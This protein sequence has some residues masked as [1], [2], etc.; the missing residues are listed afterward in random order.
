[1]F[2]IGIVGAGRLSR[3][4]LRH[5]SRIPDTSFVYFDQESQY[6]EALATEY[7]GKVVKKFSD[8]LDCV[9][10]ID[11]ITPNSI[12][13]E[14]AVAS[15]NAGKHTFIEKPLDV[16]CEAAKPVVEAANNSNVTVQVGHVLRYF[17]MYNKAHN[18][19]N[20]G[21]VGVPAAIRMTRGGGMPGGEAGWFADHKL[22]GGIFVDLAIHD[23][24][25]LL[26]SV[27]P[28]KE[29]YAKSVGAKT[30][31]GPD[32]GLA[33]L[34]F[35]NGCIAHVESTW[36]DPQESRTAFEICGPD[37]LLDYDSR[38]SATLRSGNKLEQ[39]HLL[40]DDPFF[41]QLNDFV[42]CARQGIP[43][44]ISVQEA[45]KALELAEACRTS[46]TTGLPVF[47]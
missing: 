27:G 20:S 10:A 23:L 18:M 37:G 46:A 38:N 2:T 28:V 17:A 26:W 31:S 5:L 43:A 14:Y 40:E 42:N 41:L 39:N 19:I 11:I 4:H 44:K 22:S 12:H 35:E 15:I 24:D 16:S 6:A 36:M 45:Y 8:L 1:M 25:W 3:V 34:T 29:V 30:G 13:A 47:L 21:A 33:T 32:Y 9:D 7:H